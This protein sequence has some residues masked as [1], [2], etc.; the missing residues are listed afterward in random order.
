MRKGVKQNDIC[1]IN[2]YKKY[3]ILYFL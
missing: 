2:W 3:M 1:L